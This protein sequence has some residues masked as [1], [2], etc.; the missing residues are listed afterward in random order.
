M[1]KRICVPMMTLFLLLVSCSGIGE[2]E[3]ADLRSRYQEMVGC[4]MEAIVSCD[5][6][7]M[8]WE[9]VLKCDY[10]PEGESTVEVLSPESVAGVKAV[11]SDSDWRLVYDDVCLNAGALSREELSPAL[12]LPRLMSAMRDGWL[13][14]KNEES[15]QEIPCLRMSLD[16]S[17]SQGGKIVSTLWL[18]QEDGT[19]LRG[20]ISVDGEII[21]TAEFTDFVFYDTIDLIE[22][23]E[24]LS[25]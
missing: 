22:N 24:A 13:L 15:W 7:G 20:E 18:L 1:R 4:C 16:Q 9:A 2:T 11:F 21:L 12:C 10:I 6:A 17:G 19:P 14:E 5:Q 25:S 23:V 8:E 3:R